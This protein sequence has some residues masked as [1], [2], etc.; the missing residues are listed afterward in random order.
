MYKIKLGIKIKQKHPNIRYLSSIILEPLIAANTK[1]GD[2]LPSTIITLV[3][4]KL[5]FTL[6]LLGYD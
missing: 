1:N 5:S 6:L 2:K 3:K 4:P